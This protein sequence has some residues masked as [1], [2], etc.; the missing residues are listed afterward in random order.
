MLKK[1]ALAL[2]LSCAATSAQAATFV[3]TGGS[4]GAQAGQT[5]VSDFNGATD[6]LVSGSNFQFLTGSS[7]NGAQPDPG[8]GTRYLSI[9]G[10]GEAL[11]SLGN[12]SSFGLDVGSLDSYNTLFVQFADGSEQQITGNMIFNGDANGNQHSAGS[13]GRILVTAD[14]GQTITGLRLT[15]GSNSFEVDNLAVTA[16]P[17]PATWALML[18]GFGLVG[19]GLRSRRTHSAPQAA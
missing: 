1:F 3:F 17:E 19:A 11:I 13:N 2:A 14:A 9:L 12:A 10:G 16:V 5:I 6:A 7:G 18:V 15:S 8:D 4:Y